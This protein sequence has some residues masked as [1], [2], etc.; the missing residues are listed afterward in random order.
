[1]DEQKRQI[2]IGPQRECEMANNAG[3]LMMD[4]LSE[5]GVEVI[6]GLSGDEINGMETALGRTRNKTGPTHKTEGRRIGLEETT[7]Q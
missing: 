4:L 6:L 7:I 1:M 2:R 3:D 5:C